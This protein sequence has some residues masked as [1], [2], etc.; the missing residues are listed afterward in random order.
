G[1]A[2]NG[3][4]YYMVVL[5]NGTLYFGSTEAMTGYVNYIVY[6]TYNSVHTILIPLCTVSGEII[7]LIGGKVRFFTAF[8]IPPNRPQHRRPREFNSQISLYFILYYFLSCRIQNHCLNSRQR[9][10]RM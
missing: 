5:V 6:P 2:D 8:I 9:I 10:S 1:K 7:P 4:F 3:G